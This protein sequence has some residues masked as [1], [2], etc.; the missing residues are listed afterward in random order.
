MSRLFRPQGRSYGCSYRCT[1]QTRRM[2]YACRFRPATPPNCLAIRLIHTKST[3]KFN[4]LSP[5]NFRAIVFF[6]CATHPR[7]RTFPYRNDRKTPGGAQRPPGARAE[8]LRDMCPGSVRRGFRNIGRIAKGFRTRRE[9]VELQGLGRVTKVFRDRSGSKGSSEPE[10][11]VGRPA[12]VDR[13]RKASG[14][15]Q[16]TMRRPRLSTWRLY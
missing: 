13:I 16:G 5:E 7:R 8:R 3:R 11:L 14:V 15:S 12:R 9:T 6:A 10:Q 2:P 1:T 4:N